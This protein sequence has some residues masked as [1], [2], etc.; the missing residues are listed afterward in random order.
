MDSFLEK[1]DIEKKR[2]LKEIDKMKEETMEKIENQINASKEEVIKKFLKRKKMIKDELD[3]LENLTKAS[4][5]LEN[6]IPEL[7]KVNISS[8]SFSIQI[9]NEMS[10]KSKCRDATTRFL[11]YAAKED[12]LCEIVSN[13][14]ISDLIIQ[15]NFPHS[16]K[17]EIGFLDIFYISLKGSG[18]SK[19][20]FT[21]IP[22]T[23]NS[24]G[25]LKRVLSSTDAIEEIIMINVENNNNII[26]YSLLGLE[27]SEKTLKKITLDECQL[28]MN[29]NKALSE[30][31][32]KCSLIETIN[33]N[34]SDNLKHG[35]KN[36]C[37]GLVKS[38]N[39]LMNLSLSNC[40]LEFSHSEY[41]KD[42]LKVDC[43]SLNNLLKECIK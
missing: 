1:E 32:K 10:T 29:D 20:L 9:K 35:L 15:K 13:D 2:L 6:L 40:D 42:L 28:S 26:Y 18:N 37:E 39:S 19:I 27:N 33:L 16:I 41:L 25:N 17:K 7:P 43:K 12:I 14:E 3:K 38:K 30:V 11:N 22:K 34:G 36:I 4:D 24:I 23:V 8:I 21:E 31:L 5:K